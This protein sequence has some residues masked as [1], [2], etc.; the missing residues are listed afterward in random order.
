[1]ALKRN[2]IKQIMSDVHKDV[3][4]GTV[5][6]SGHDGFIAEVRRRSRAAGLSEAEVDELAKQPELRRDGAVRTP[7]G[8]SQ[9]HR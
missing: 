7:A 5:K 8:R 1:M 6:L 4:A 2:P 3:R 9:S